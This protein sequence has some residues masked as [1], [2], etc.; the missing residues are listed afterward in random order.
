MKNRRFGDPGGDAIVK[1]CG[2]DRPRSL[3]PQDGELTCLVLDGAAFRCQLE[4]EGATLSGRSDDGVGPSP[5]D[6][7]PDHNPVQIGQ[8]ADAHDGAEIPT[9]R[10]PI[11]KRLLRGHEV[12][13][14]EG[15]GDAEQ[16]VGEAPQ[17]VRKPAECADGHQYVDEVLGNAGQTFGRLGHRT[18]CTEN[19]AFDF[20]FKPD[21]EK[22]HQNRQNARPPVGDVQTVEAGEYRLEQPYAYSQEETPGHEGDGAGAEEQ[23]EGDRTS[24]L[25]GGSI[26]G[27]PPDDDRDGHD[28]QT[29][30]A[31][32]GDR[33]GDRAGT[34]VC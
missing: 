7:V 4:L 6:D 31:A 33:T 9:P 30:P 32:C 17:S 26:E 14:G 23:T 16:L 18:R 3:N 25:P 10:R 15:E 22:H 13:G 12:P 5:P 2:S 24:P 29:D 21:V 19:P 28:Q 34:S 8:D 20:R 27:E 11:G 1:M